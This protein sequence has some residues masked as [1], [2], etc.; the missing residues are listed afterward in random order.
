MQWGPRNAPFQQHRP[1]ALRGQE[2]SLRISWPPDVDS[3]AKHTVAYKPKARAY[4]SAFC[5]INQTKDRDS[6][7][8]KEKSFAVGMFWATDAKLW[9]KQ[10]FSVQASVLGNQSGSRDSIVCLCEHWQTLAYVDNSWFWTSWSPVS[11]TEN[12]VLRS[13]VDISEYTTFPL[14]WGDGISYKKRSCKVNC[15]EKVNKNVSGELLRKSTSALDCTAVDI[16]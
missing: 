15:N 13:S 10:S 5:L 6:G 4:R 1:G 9:T 16:W 12:P 3:T 8:D 7:V 14:V 11:I 2:R